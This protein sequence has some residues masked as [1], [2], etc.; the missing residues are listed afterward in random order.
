VHT[1]VELLEVAQV[2]QGVRGLERRVIK[3]S[4]RQS[5]DQRHLTAFES[6]PDA[7]SRTSLLTLMTFAAGFPVTGTL[8]AAESFN[9]ML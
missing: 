8:A 5:P 9:S 7:P 6:K 1:L 4:L 3:T 2:H